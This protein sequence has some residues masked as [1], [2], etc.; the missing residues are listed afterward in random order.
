MNLRMVDGLAIFPFEALART[1]LRYMNS[2]C[3][4]GQAATF[5]H[6]AL[7]EGGFMWPERTQIGHFLIRHQ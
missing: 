4:S 5:S 3:I 6:A 7:V 2:T 1:K